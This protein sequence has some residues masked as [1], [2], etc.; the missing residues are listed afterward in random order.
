MSTTKAAFTGKDMITKWDVLEFGISLS[1]H[2]TCSRV[3]TYRFQLRLR[4]A[5]ALYFFKIHIVFHYSIIRG[6]RS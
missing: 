2:E 1:S 5:N 6:Y 4:V 3:S